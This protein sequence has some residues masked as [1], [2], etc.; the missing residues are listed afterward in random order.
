MPLMDVGNTRI[1]Y[2]LKLYLPPGTR[3]TSVHRSAEDQL[4]II[5]QRARKLGFQFA[6]KPTVGD[7]SSWEPAL[8]FLRRKAPGNPVA[9]PGR[10]LHQRG[11]AYDLVG[12]NLDAIKTAVEEA[13]RDGRIR[14]I[15]GARQNPRRE[16]LCVHVEIDGG[17]IDYEP[18]DWA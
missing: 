1:W 5:E 14:L 2:A 3:L 16:G 6:R 8:Q 18:F 4:A 7:R 15:P 9:P 10:S 12:P 13:A 17:T 11:L